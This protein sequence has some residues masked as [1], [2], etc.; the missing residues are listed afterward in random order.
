MGHVDEQAAALS[1]SGR[2]DTQQRSR[3]EDRRD[4]RRAGEST[5]RSPAGV[6]DRHRPALTSPIYMMQVYDRVL[7]SGRL[8]TLVLLTLIAALAVLVLGLLEMVRIKM[9]AR[10]G[11]WLDWRLSPEV[12]RAGLRGAIHGDAPNAQPLRDL[13]QIRACLGGPGCNTIFD[14]PWTPIFLTVIWLMHPILGFVGI[15]SAFALFILAVVNEY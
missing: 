8:E 2:I 15:G 7:W 12:I 10:I 6:P 13:T 9:L 4:G 1:L 3:R 5:P 11:Q 14:G